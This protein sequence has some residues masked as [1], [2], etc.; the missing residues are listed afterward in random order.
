MQRIEHRE[1]CA[2]DIRGRAVDCGKSVE[3]R[4]T[5]HH[6]VPVDRVGTIAA[7]DEVIARQGVGVVGNSRNEGHERHAHRAVVAAE[8]IRGCEVAESEIRHELD[9]RSDDVELEWLHREVRDDRLSALR[10]FV[11]NTGRGTDDAD[12]ADDLRQVRSVWHGVECAVCEDHVRA[13]AAEDCIVA[14]LTEEQVVAIAAENGVLVGRLKVDEDEFRIPRAS[15][16]VDELASA[17]EIRRAEHGE[18]CTEEFCGKRRIVEAHRED[19]HLDDA[20]NVADVLQQDVAVPRTVCV[21]ARGAVRI[22]CTQNH[23]AVAEGDIVSGS[24]AGDVHAGA[25]ND[26]VVARSTIEQICAALTE[27][28]ILTIVT[29]QGVR[30]GHE[31]DIVKARNRANHERRE[32]SRIGA[33]CGRIASEH[34]AR[35]DAIVAKQ[36]IA[37][38]PAAE[39]VAGIGAAERVVTTGE[40]VV[41]CITVDEVATLLAKDE[42]IALVAANGVV[43][44]AIG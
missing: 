27:Q 35:N 16:G 22:E 32:R 11:W 15:V 3:Q 26:F 34:L 21:D 12:A 4:R 17:L 18:V 33:P 42:V 28:Y 2:A 8:C 6:I 14:A 41:A 7:V 29:E 36:H 9:L 20:G 31:V 13:C 39:H 43:T 37:A 23:S 38:G 19:V 40:I 30:A 10:D 44:A 25:A 24:T 1:D 5:D